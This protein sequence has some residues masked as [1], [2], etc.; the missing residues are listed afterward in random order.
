MPEQEDSDDPDVLRSEIKRLRKLLTEHTSPLEVILKRRGFNIFRKESLDDLLIPAEKFLDE[1]YEMMKKYSFRLFLREV[2]RHQG[3]FSPDMVTRY[4]AA[5]VTEG[6]IGFMEAVGLVRRAPGGFCLIRVPI[7]SFG[8]TL[9]WLVAE[10]FRR[11][12]AAESI[13][14]IRFRR[15]GVG[16]DYDLIVKVDGAILYMEIKSSPPKQIYQNEIAS[17][18]KRI[19]DLS[20][21]IGIFFMDTELR[22]QDKIIPMFA[23]ELRKDDNPP[24]ILRIEKEL[25]Q[26][27]GKVFIINARE[28]IISN[29]GKVLSFYFR[30]KQ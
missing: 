16:G 6:Y 2:I 25:F 28:S 14:G 4:A 23:E 12:F 22:M 7:K 9:E 8:E 26:I 3:G 27:S 30:R 5:D 1:F 11:E 17:F 20:P 13:R 24:E 18:F 21:D 19:Q 29:I 15:P 10:I